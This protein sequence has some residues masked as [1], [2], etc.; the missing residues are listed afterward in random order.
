MFRQPAAVA[1]VSFIMAVTDAINGY[2]LFLGRE[3]E[4]ERV[5]NDKAGFPLLKMLGV[6]AGS[7]EFS[8]RVVMPLASGY[9]LPHF[10]VS[11]VP[12]PEMAA[13]ASEAL[14]LAPATRAKLPQAR[15]WRHLLTLLVLDPEFLA[16]L[17]RSI[18][19][20]Q[21]L[22]LRK[23]GSG[24]AK[25]DER[26]IAGAVD[27]IAMFEIR[28]WAANILDLGEPLTLEFFLDNLF[29]GTTQTALFR[30]DIQEK[31][32][33]EGN[34]G[35]SFNVPAAHHA[36][37]QV[38]R[39]LTVREA[40][41]HLPI[42]IPMRMRV[43]QADAMDSLF[44]LKRE[45]E[46]V[47][48]ALER[49]QAALPS[50]LSDTE[51]P[52]SMYDAYQRT[53]R[54]AL[55]ADR[56]R[57]SAEIFAFAPGFSVVIVSSGE[58]STGL[59]PSINSVR[60][61]IYSRWECV[62]CAAAQQHEISA[63]LETLCSGD[64]RIK[65]AHAPSGVTLPDALNRG[66]TSATGEYV[67]VLRDGDLL[68]EDALLEITRALQDG[69]HALLT[70]DEDLFEREGMRARYSV[71]VLKTAF[72]YDHLLSR[73]YIGNAFACRKD[74][75]LDLNGLDAD[76]GQAAEYD[77]ILRAIEK[78]KPQGIR[79]IERIVYHRRSELLEQAGEDESAQEAELRLACISAHLKRTGA[80]AIAEA[81]A[82]PLGVPWPRSQRIV[83]SLPESVP[84]VSIIVPTRDR[85]DLLGPCLDSV[86]GTRGHYPGRVEIIVMDNQSV[87]PE[88]HALF[89]R[90][91]QQDGVSVISYPSAF[92]WSAINNMAARRATGDILLFLNNDTRVLTDGWLRELV[93]N[94]AR[95]DVGAVG[96]RLLYEDGTIQH[97]G[98]VLGGR[99]VHEGIGQRPG[100]GGYLG[101]TALQ[102]NCSAVTGACLATRKSLFV[103]L[104]GFDEN[105][106]K[107][108][109]NDVDYCLKVRATGLSVIYTPFAT[110][111]HFESKSRGLD[112][113]F[114]KRLRS[115]NELG[116]M[117]SR[118]GDAIENDPFYNARFNRTGRPFTRLRPSQ[119]LTSMPTP[120]REDE[121]LW[122]YE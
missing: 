18:P 47:G 105:H 79:Q 122:E 30:R 56:E 87:E 6:F 106:L 20:E 100:E 8:D 60:R 53:A 34:Y 24:P 2:R 71:P 37:L 12:G 41:S 102:R 55:H 5:V 93:S 57:L 52:L 120:A 101:R 22:S 108:A 10:R 70:F 89:A 78:I 61:Q 109:F 59:V 54:R 17:G 36:D 42:A 32:G 33:G 95:A 9:P 118:W 90:L 98:V 58:T 82:D 45:V 85:A 86:L 46:V 3:P 43:G 23:R 111:Y 35:F 31:L 94:A 72:D 110:L 81:H 62:V 119:L 50:V 103:E 67:L 112:D 44:R 39:L 116:T 29:I 48:V 115:Q 51:Y 38:E 16:K 49:L 25:A 104:G 4:S 121:E 114:S 26:E 96:V 92:N 28:G 84:A 1:G 117:R 15:T 75:F 113:D 40:T 76:L 21:V 99:A 63:V 65:A 88:T 68:A 13:W 64:G 97:G 83:W 7:R 74:L 73:N 91:T 11:A 107:V 77:F 80:S 14:P 66:V 69:P 27:D 19:E